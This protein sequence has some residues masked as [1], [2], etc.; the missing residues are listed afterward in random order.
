MEYS[1]SWWAAVVVVVVVVLLSEPDMVNRSGTVDRYL[2]DFLLH[3]A[4]VD[5]VDNDFRP[6]ISRAIVIQRE[7]RG[8]VWR[9]QGKSNDEPYGYGGRRRHSTHCLLFDCCGAAACIEQR[10]N[11]E[12]TPYQFLH[13]CL[14]R[15]YGALTTWQRGCH[16]DPSSP[17]GFRIFWIQQGF[18]IFGV[19]KVFVSFDPKGFRSFGA[20]GGRQSK[21][22][23]NTTNID[24]HRQ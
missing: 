18:R 10:K 11:M 19:E 12:A 3:E 22:H 23:I 16:V 6:T 17:K 5:T 2:F 21:L 24:R 7:T 1:Q 14:R 4:A 8:P 9:R 20:A 13:R 15:K